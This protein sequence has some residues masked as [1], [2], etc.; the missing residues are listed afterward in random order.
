ML[1]SA[2]LAACATVPNGLSPEEIASF[3]LTGVKVAF[4]PDAPIRWE[5]GMNAYAKA[6]N[7]APDQ[8]LNAADSEAGKTFLRDA[9]TPKIKEAME[10]NVS[11]K[12][13]G[14]RPVRIEMTVRQFDILPIAQRI[15]IGSGGNFMAADVTLLDAKSGAILLSYPKLTEVVPAAGGV[16]GVAV[17][18]MVEASGPSPADRVADT[19]AVRYVR[20]LVEKT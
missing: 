11:R 6:N 3:K 20:W 12:L 2:A 9:L 18:A 1:V 14:L 5:D 13:A 7:V 16:V 15:I 19:F 17:Q 4:A 10:R 8:M